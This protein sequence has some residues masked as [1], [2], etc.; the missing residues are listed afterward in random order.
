[1]SKFIFALCIFLGLGSAFAAVPRDSILTL[2][3]ENDD[4]TFNGDKHYTQGLRLTYMHPDTRTPAWGVWLADALPHFGMKI[5]APRVGFTIG[6]SIYTPDNLATDQVVMNDR[7]YAG[8]LYLGLVL[9]REGVTSRREIPVLDTFQ[10]HTG[11]IGPESFAETV[12]NWWHSS[13]GFIIP[14]GWQHQLETEPGF[15]FKHLRQWKYSTGREGFG[16]EFI[17]HVGGSLGNVATFANL[18]AM[19]RVGY[20]LPDDWGVQTIDSLGVQTGSRSDKAFGVY[21]F[22]TLD[23]RAV[24]HNAFLDGNTFQ[25]SHHID[26]CIFVGELRTGLVLAFRRADISATYAMRTREYRGQPGNESFGS[27]AFNFKF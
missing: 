1:M 4:L 25:G 11:I 26:K 6:Q 21:G 18:G 27:I 12:Q 17:P 13:T 2:I 3:E 9:Q 10:F 22:A 8:W 16:A 14:R 15:V 7:P 23:G 20:N 5:E 19:V 24:A